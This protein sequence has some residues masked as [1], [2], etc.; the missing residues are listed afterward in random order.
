MPG[1][2]NISGRRVEQKNKKKGRGETGGGKRKDGT[3][4]LPPLRS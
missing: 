2:K 3:R 1:G 4:T